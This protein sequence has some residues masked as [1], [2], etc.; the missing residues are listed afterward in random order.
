MGPKIN[1]SGPITKTFTSG[2]NAT[3][4]IGADAMTGATSSAAGAAGIV[5][6]P[7]AGDQDK[8]LT[9]A[10]TW[11]KVGNGNIDWSTIGT[12]ISLEGLGTPPKLTVIT[13]NSVLVGNRFF[14]VNVVAK[15]TTANSSYTQIGLF[16]LPLHV[17]YDA[18]LAAM[19]E[20][21]GSVRYSYVEA[22]SDKLIIA[23]GAAVSD[24]NVRITGVIPIG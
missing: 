8:V 14:V 11:A 20:S 17:G 22:S 9:G 3:I 7:V 13:N 15:I 10:G 23:T 6:K 12:P 5:P 24:A 19:L 16:D 4:T 18:P 21:G 1:V 2:A